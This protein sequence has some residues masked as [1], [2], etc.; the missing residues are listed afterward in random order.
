MKD[1]FVVVVVVQ[2]FRNFEIFLIGCDEIVVN[3]LQSFEISEVAGNIIS[4]TIRQTVNK[5][6]A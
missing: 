3:K 1:G 4:Q 2:M 5:A 6:T